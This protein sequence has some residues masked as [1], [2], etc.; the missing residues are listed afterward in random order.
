MFYRERS[1]EGKRTEKSKKKRKTT[2]SHK[3]VSIFALDY[4]IKI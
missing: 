4:K 3:Q 1:R 2:K